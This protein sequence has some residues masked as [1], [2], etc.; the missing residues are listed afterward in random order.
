[1]KNRPINWLLIIFSSISIGSLLAISEKLISLK[2]DSI[3]PDS[4]ELLKFRRPGTIT[5]L[6]TNGEVIQKI[7]PAT[8]EKITSEDMPILIKKAFIAAEDRRFYKHKGVDFWGI[9]R[10]I[11]NN[12]NQRSISEGGSTI[13]QQLA[14]IVF[15]NQDRTITRKLK[16][17][18]LAFKIE[19]QLDKEK[20]FE[21]YLNKV[22]LGSNAYGI[23]DAAWIY[24]SKTPDLLKLE[25]VALIAGLPPAPSKYSPLVNPGLALQRRSIVLKRMLRQGFISEA[26]F[27]K[28]MVT[29]INLDPSTPKYFNSAAPFFS[30][31]VFQ[32]LPSLIS[33]EQLE[34]GG[35]TIRTSLNLKWQLKAN[36]IINAQNKSNLEGAIVSIEPQT[37]LV[38][39]LV[40][41]MDFDDN[42]F[43][44]ATQALR[45]PGSIFK[46]FI[47]A[48]AISQG[49]QSGDIVEDV[50]KCWGDYCPKNFDNK[51]L[52]KVTVSESFK[53]SLNSVAVDLLDKVGFE[54]VISIANSLGVGQ[55]I[56]LEK[57][58]SLAIGVFEE[59]V[60]NM[61]AAY[62]GITNKG[63]YH[64]PTPF[65]E[66]RGPSN[67]IIWSKELNRAKGYKALDDKVADTINEML[68]KVV[69][70]GT[71]TDAN[72]KNRVV[73]GKTGTSEG[74]RDVWFIGSIPQLTTGIWF[75]HDNNQET[76]NTS[77]MAAWSWKQYMQEIEE[78]LPP[79]KSTNSFPDNQQ[80]KID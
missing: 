20:I 21:Q 30:N 52:G 61:T 47:Y 60:L 38:R 34:V 26:E 70:D 1:M 40:G 51:Y 77:R 19:R 57:Y 5:L 53:Y 23:A 22:Y 67:R 36:E 3:L 17:V 8:R 48:A 13:T 15:L 28:S 80:I 49:F 39:V 7:G 33:R 41:G 35:L 18:A 12:L 56:K 25:E 64:E 54:E 44:R 16:E 58:Y 45:P 27:S 76:K 66:I 29:K 2:I 24:F 75:G 14:R 65:E 63:L 68:K 46:V 59:T 73:A 43:N 11:R 79:S 10:A 69:S 50:P 78:S 62:A 9:T 72:L 55:E 6:S 32:K 37:G 31:W 71:G 42:Q 4:S 74:A